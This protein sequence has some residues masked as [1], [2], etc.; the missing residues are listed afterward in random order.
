MADDIDRRTFQVTYY[1]E[2]E[3]DHSMDVEALVPALAGY[4]KLIHESNALLNGDKTKVKVLVASNFEH[5][6]FQINFELIRTIIHH[7]GDLLTHDNLQTATD[8]LKIIGVV[9]WTGT[10]LFDFLKKKDGRKIESVERPPHSNNVT[11]KFEGD[12]N[13]VNVTNNVFLLAENKRVLEAVEGALT[14]VEKREASRLAF[15]EN[16]HPDHPTASFDREAI[17]SIIRSCEAGPDPVAAELAKSKSKTVTAT[18]Y[19]YSPVFDKKAPNWRFRYRGKP[20]YADVSE[21]SIAQDAIKRGGSFTNDRYR[22]RMLVTEPES[23]E[24]TPHYKIEEVLDFTPAEQQTALPLKKPR[25][26]KP[27]RTK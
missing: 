11:I 9:R 15:R 25:K 12:E 17:K 14:P 4:G 10:S 7:V 20:I 1:G 5:K 18:L 3:D 19:V 26:K 21:T 6:C 16:D 24:G 2:D 23:D 27:L 8:L 22:V 13:A